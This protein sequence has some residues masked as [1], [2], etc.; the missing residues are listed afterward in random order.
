MHSCIGELGETKLGLALV[1]SWPTQGMGNGLTPCREVVIF[2]F[3]ACSPLL[4]WQGAYG[5]RL[6][7]HTRRSEIFCGRN[8]HPREYCAPK[9]AIDPALFG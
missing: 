1:A 6:D 8:W 4:P 2:T 5:D 3:A 7:W 9:R